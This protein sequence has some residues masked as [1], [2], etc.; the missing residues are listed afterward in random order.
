MNENEK[1]FKNGEVYIGFV[2]YAEDINNDV[3]PRGKIRPVVIFEDPEEKRLFAC[4]VSGQI[5]KPLERKNGYVIQ[6]WKDAG[7]KKPSIVACNKENIREIN[8]SDIR[9]FVGRLTDRDVKGMLIKHI[10]VTERE[11]KKELEKKN[12]LE[13]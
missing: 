5:D 13:R 1:E 11:Y 3:N 12:E 9:D 8:K 10:K 7:F 2:R 6:D 4:K